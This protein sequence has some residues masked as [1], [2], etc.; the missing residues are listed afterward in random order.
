MKKN[1]YKIKH[2]LLNKIFNSI[3]YIFILYAC[4]IF[5]LIN[6]AFPKSYVGGI[7]GFNRQGTIRNCYSNQSIEV[8]N[9]DKLKL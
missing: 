9:A 4:S 3:M 6:Y 7:T 2:L 1:F 8:N 5:F